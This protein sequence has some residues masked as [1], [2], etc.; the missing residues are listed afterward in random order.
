M[1]SVPAFSH[2]FLLLSVRVTTHFV[3]VFLTNG[4][5]RL[6]LLYMWGH[7][8]PIKNAFGTLYSCLNNS[9]VW[10]TDFVKHFLSQL[11][12]NNELCCF[13]HHPDVWCNFIPLCPIWQN[14]FLG[15]ALHSATN[16]V[17]CL[18]VAAFQESL[19]LLSWNWAV[20]LWNEQA[21]CNPVH[22]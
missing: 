6:H 16:L 1:R 22:L 11:M 20:F 12:Y 9:Q 8:W 5:L 10:L 13:E 15:I 19:L 2:V 3:L 18:S 7:V 21:R 17:I 14:F 4:T